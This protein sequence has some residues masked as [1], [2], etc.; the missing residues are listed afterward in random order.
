MYALC[1][2]AAAAKN[3]ELPEC[4]VKK[5]EE[6]FNA[7]C[8]FT[9]QYND[10]NGK[11]K[12]TTTQKNGFKCYNIMCIENGYDWFRRAVFVRVRMCS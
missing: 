1:D 7:K 6:I 5:D 11:E 2:V 4:D 8:W 10:K 9:S 12:A 3:E